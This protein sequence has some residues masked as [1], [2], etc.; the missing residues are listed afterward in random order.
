[1]PFTEIYDATEK[2][3]ARDGLDRVAPEDP[4]PGDLVWIEFNV[5][6]YPDGSVKNGTDDSSRKPVKGGK[7]SSWRCTLDILHIYLLHSGPG[8]FV[9]QTDVGAEEF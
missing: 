5:L 3:G 2:F 1:M 4:H 8:E 7:W 9:D 6:R